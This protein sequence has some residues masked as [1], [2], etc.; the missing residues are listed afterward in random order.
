MFKSV[1]IMRVLVKIGGD[2]LLKE[3]KE[4]NKRYIAFY[5]FFFAT[6]GHKV[7]VSKCS[8]LLLFIVDQHDSD[9]LVTGSDDK[10]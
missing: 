7:K 9:H 4:C 1:V 6:R 5:T 3:N 8:L 10:K 2:A